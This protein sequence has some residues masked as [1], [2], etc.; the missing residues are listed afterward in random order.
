MD[1]ARPDENPINA[2]T[3]REN[4]PFPVWAHFEFTGKAAEYFK[5]WIVNIVLSIVTLGIYSAWAKVRKERYFYGNTW[6]NGSSF[7]YTADPVKILKGRIIAFVFFAAFGIVINLFPVFSIYALAALCLL[8]PFM[9]VTSTAF[10]LRNSVYRNMRF[11]FSRDY[12]D[13]YKV[14]VIPLSF[15]IAATAIMY[16]VISINE[17]FPPVEGMEDQQRR[18]EDFLFS[19]FT[20]A[21]FP[22]IPWMIFLMRKFI[23]N[24]TH[25]GSA[26]GLFLASAGTFYAIFLKFIFISIVAFTLLAFLTIPMMSLLFANDISMQPIDIKSEQLG[27]FYLGMVVLTLLFYG[28]SFFTL[29]YLKARLT[30][31]TFNSAELGPLCFESSLRGRD[32]GWLYL[33][34]TIAIFVSLG[35]L[36]PW[37]KIRMARYKATKTQLLAKDMDAINTIEQDDPNAFG[38]ELGELFDF[39]FGL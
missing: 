17:I 28:L 4:L 10:R 8:F 30:N 7:Q 36:I 19:C 24:R 29:G 25:Y 20:L 5:I 9:L 21:L 16:G 23:V 35:L 38:E 39:D 11:R 13:A 1:L 26:Q 2:P 3:N 14:F 22:V 31:V 32:L 12:L 37:A 34:N 6:V 18:R 33:S 27:V 15:V